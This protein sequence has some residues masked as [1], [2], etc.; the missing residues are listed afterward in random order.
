MAIDNL[1]IEYDSESFC[2]LN[3]KVF[4]ANVG[5]A[6]YLNNGIAVGV[7]TDLFLLDTD[8][9]EEA[10]LNGSQIKPISF[11]LEDYQGNGYYVVS[12][13]G[14][15]KKLNQELVVQNI[16]CIDSNNRAVWVRDRKTNT[17]QM[18]FLPW[19]DYPFGARYT[20]EIDQIEPLG[21]RYEA[22]DISKNVNEMNDQRFYKMDSTLMVIEQ[23]P[24]YR[25][26]LYTNY[27]GIWIFGCS[28]N[29][30]HG[31]ISNT[32]NID[33]LIQNGGVINGNVK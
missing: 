26:L 2:V 10:V 13:N 14:E 12:E 28:F 1:L 24:V 30:I 21:W 4:S 31:D 16:R 25:K 22:V 27:S 17:I 8:F 23:L 9:S 15:V 19:E 3:R 11:V 32:R 29:C 7:E 18:A 33:F 20:Y 6:C 5:C